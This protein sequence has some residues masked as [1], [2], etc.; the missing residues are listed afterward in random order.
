M[1]WQSSCSHGTDYEIFFLDRL[2]TFSSGVY[3]SKVWLLKE[4][5]KTAPNRR[6]DKNVN[7]YEIIAHCKELIKQLTE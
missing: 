1:T 2:G 7:Q 6:W 5:L 4:Y 3:Q